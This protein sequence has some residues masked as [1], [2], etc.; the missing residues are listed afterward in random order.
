MRILHLFD[1]RMTPLDFEILRLLVE[2]VR[3][4]SDAT[5]VGLGVMGAQ[6]P[7]RFAR[8]WPRPYHLGFPPPHP[9][10]T[11]PWIRRVVRQTDC[12]LIHAWGVR[13]AITATLAGLE[14]LPVLATVTSPHLD[15]REVRW[16]SKAR[17]APPLPMACFSEVIRRKLVQRG[18]PPTELGVIRPGLDVDRLTPGT[19][20]QQRDRLGITEGQ[21]VLITCPP[22]SR[23]GGQYFAVWA[24]ALLEQAFP[25]V[26]LLVPGVSKEQRRLKRF[27][28][29][30]AKPHL[31]IFPDPS[32]GFFELLAAADVCVSPAVGPVATTA[33]AWVMA[34]GVPLV[35]SRVPAL[36]EV[37]TDGQ[38]ASLSAPG[39]P[40]ELAGRIRD[41]LRDE[42]L[43][44][45]LRDAAR[46]AGRQLFGSQRMLEEYHRAYA[47]LVAGRTLFGTATADA[48]EA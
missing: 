46:R 30:F 33:L 9:L 25:D 35:G 22:P 13:P 20:G 6:V 36:T 29:G 2:S 11:V 12:D 14:R 24:T 48:A 18:Y 40:A 4:S 16:L 23:E 26:R 10:A 42:G 34:A 1:D 21:P 5:V 38:T 28:H 27:V 43:A 15:R 41:L 17:N 8:S 7:R 3:G 45:R 37:L 19:R 32:V 47:R 39:R 31:Y 44:D